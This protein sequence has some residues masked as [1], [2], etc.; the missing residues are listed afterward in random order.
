MPE[1]EEHNREKYK[2]IIYHGYIHI[3]ANHEEDED[4]G[5]MYG[6]KNPKY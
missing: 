3:L 4:P 5:N 6:K 2:F 1:S